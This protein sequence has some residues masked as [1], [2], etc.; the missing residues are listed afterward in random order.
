M[1]PWWV[2]LLVASVACA[3]GLMLGSAWA[4][5]R[6]REDAHRGRATGRPPGK[7]DP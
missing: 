4:Y 6:G 2:V 1:V 5:R 3:A 7:H